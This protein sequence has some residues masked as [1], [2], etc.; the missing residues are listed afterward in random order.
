MSLPEVEGSLGSRVG[1]EG[2]KFLSRDPIGVKDSPLVSP[3][4][5]SL[6]VSAEDVLP[7]INLV[8]FFQSYEFPSLG[9]SSKRFLDISIS[10]SL[11]QDS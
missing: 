6:D 1:V 8:H 7:P 4:E 3:H 5:F 9:G 10:S 2:L 11:V